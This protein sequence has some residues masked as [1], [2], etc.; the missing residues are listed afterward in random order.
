MRVVHDFPPNWDE[1]N[2]VFKVAGKPVIFCYGDRI[3]NPSQID[4]TPALYA[5][6]LMHSRQQGDDPAGWWRRY[7]DDIAFRFEQE[8][9]AHQAEYIAAMKSAP[10]RHARRTYAKAIAQRLA[11]PLY[12]HVVSPM[13]AK[14]L[15]KEAG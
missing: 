12:G 4:V 10:N 7:I 8:L 1:V 11:G 15:I 6:E 5:H 9:A 3:Y 14:R 2:A 13:E